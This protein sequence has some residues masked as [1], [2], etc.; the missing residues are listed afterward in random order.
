MHFNLSEIMTEAWKIVRRHKGKGSSEP[1]ARLLSRALKSVWW[2]AKQTMRMVAQRSASA[3]AQSKRTVANL[4]REIQSIE[5]GSR[6]Q[7]PD[8]QRINS[9]QAACRAACQHE[10][11]AA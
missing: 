10:G 7:A 11:M 2:D 4:R 6:L 1:T 8:F 5:N 9:L 3:T